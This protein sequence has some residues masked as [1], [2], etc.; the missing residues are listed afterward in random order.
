MKIW[1]DDVRKMPTGYDMW[2]KNA[3]DAI[4]LIETGKVT[5]IS[6]DHDLGG[7]ALIYSGGYVA[8]A[9]E[10]L[11]FQ[12]KIPRLTWECHSMNPEGKRYIIF[13]MKSADRFW[14]LTES[15]NHDIIHTE[16]K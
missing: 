8:N 11:A 14:D 15:K 3:H 4:S 5:H 10:Q 7:F 16:E 2:C 1:L 6:F 13:A 12:G 9:I